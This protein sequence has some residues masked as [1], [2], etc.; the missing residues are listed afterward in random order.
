MK[1]NVMMRVASV[2]LVAVMLTTCVISGTFAKYVSDGTAKDTARVAKWGVTVTGAADEATQGANS[3]FLENYNDTVV[4][5][6]ANVAV[7]APG[8]TGTLADFTVAGQPEV[9]VRVTYSA[10]L[11]FGGVWEDE[12]GDEYCP[13]IFNVNGVLFYIGNGTITDIAGLKTA[14]QN[15]IIACTNDYQAN[16][17]LNVVGDDLSVSWIW[18][19]DDEVTGFKGACGQNDID[20][21]F[22]GN[23]ATTANAPTIS[24]TVTASVTQID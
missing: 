16:Q 10:T 5:S 22:L 14:V 18:Q 23:T 20:D 2:L 19:F 3:L 21:T 13:I 12:G 11:D 8:T 4:S 6:E 24:L 15:A 17:P 1:K 7:V 9:D